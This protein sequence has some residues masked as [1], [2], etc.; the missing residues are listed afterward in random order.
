METK[1]AIKKIINKLFTEEH[2]TLETMGVSIKDITENINKIEIVDRKSAR[3]II[4][5]IDFALGFS[6]VISNE[7]VEKLKGLKLELEQNY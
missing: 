3:I 1:N 4:N 2:D 5:D 6:E 7:E